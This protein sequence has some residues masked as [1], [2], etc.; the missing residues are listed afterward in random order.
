MLTIKTKKQQDN[1]VKLFWD[2]T[3]ICVSAFVIY[4]I[5][6]DNLNTTQLFSGLFVVLIL[7]FIAFKIDGIK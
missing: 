5:I 7:V 6:K 4:P 1:L 3:K 2:L